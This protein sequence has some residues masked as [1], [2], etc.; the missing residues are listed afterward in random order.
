MNTHFLVGSPQRVPCPQPRASSSGCSGDSSHSWQAGLPF[1]CVPGNSELRA[2]G[3]L[4]LRG[5]GTNRRPAAGYALGVH[6]FECPRPSS[7]L[8]VPGH[9]A[10][11]PALLHRWGLQAH[12]TAMLVRNP[13]QPICR[14]PLCPGTRAVASSDMHLLRCLMAPGSPQHVQS[15]KAG[16]KDAKAGGQ[17]PIGS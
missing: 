10:T 3:A 12:C 2:C 8:S 1:L 4:P 17:C 14:Y 9:Q 6:G 15:P 13:G 16:Q 11:E 5:G 7:R